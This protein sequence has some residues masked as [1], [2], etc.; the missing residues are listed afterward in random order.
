MVQDHPPVAV[1]HVPVRVGVLVPVYGIAEY[2]TVSPLLSV[3]VLVVEVVPDDH[4][5]VNHFTYPLPV[6]L[7][8]IYRV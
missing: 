5:L 1:L 4:V 7:I 6:P 3:R 2:W 8:F